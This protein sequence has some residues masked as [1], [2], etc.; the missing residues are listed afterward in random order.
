M[1]ALGGPR[2]RLNR[3]CVLRRRLNPCA[4]SRAAPH[5][6]LRAYGNADPYS[7]LRAYGNADP[8]SD[9]HAY[10]NAYPHPSAEDGGAA[11]QRA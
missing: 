2:C 10:G 5:S 7:N 9:L 6:N 1:R 4:Y 8:Y 11:R 3:N